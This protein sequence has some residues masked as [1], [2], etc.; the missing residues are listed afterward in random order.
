MFKKAIIILIILITVG[1]VGIVVFQQ[2]SL[3]FSHTFWQQFPNYKQIYV[4][5]QYVSKHPSAIIPDE[6]ALSYAGAAL[7]RGVN[8]VLIIADTPP[9]GKYLIGISE[10]LFNNPAIISLIFAVLS[11]I[12]LY[13][14]GK[15]IFQITLTALL[16]PCFLSFEPIFKNQLVYAPLLD[17]IQLVFLLAG[18]YFFNKGLVSKKVFFNFSFAM[19]SLGFFISTKFFITGLPIVAAYLLTLLLHKDVRRFFYLFI[20]TPL[21]LAV[22]FLSYF[23]IFAFGYSLR[24]LFGIQKYIFLYHKSQLILPFSIWPLLLFNKWYVWFGTKPVISDS[25][26]SITWPILTLGSSLVILLYLLRKIKHTSTIEVLMAWLVFYIL[27]FSFGQITSRYLVIY[28]PVLYLVSFYGIERGVMKNSFFA[29]W[30][31]S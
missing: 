4:N 28:I 30:L 26:W 29:K 15:Q 21:S 8:P 20:M 18:F 22:L 23:R 5:S 10:V 3:Y 25:Q 27:L 14:V 19:V 12:L 16:V 1:N 6:T 13:L 31:N 17:N 24:S 9:L 2:K 11:L 7:I